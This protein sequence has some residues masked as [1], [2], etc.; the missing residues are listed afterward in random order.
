[1]WYVHFVVVQNVFNNDTIY[2]L[3]PFLRKNAMQHHK[4]IKVYRYSIT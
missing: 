2:E 3:E 1:M 4:N